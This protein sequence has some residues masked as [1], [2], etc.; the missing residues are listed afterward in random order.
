MHTVFV[1]FRMYATVVQIP[2]HL[3]IYLPELCRTYIVGSSYFGSI[4]IDRHLNPKPL[5][6]KTLHPIVPLWDP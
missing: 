3:S 4:D 1:C 2:M 6:P 5:K